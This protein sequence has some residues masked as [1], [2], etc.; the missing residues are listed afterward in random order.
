MP[1]TEYF[2]A[3]NLLIWGAKSVGVCEAGEIFRKKLTKPHF[4]MFGPTIP[5]EVQKLIGAGA[6]EVERYRR[7][8]SLKLIENSPNPMPMIGKPSS[9][10]L[11]IDHEQ[12]IFLDYLVEAPNF[13][14][15]HTV[16]HEFMEQFD[17]TSGANKYHLANL[18]TRDSMWS[19]H[20][21]TLVQP[22]KGLD[23]SYVILLDRFSRAKSKTKLDGLII[24]A[25]HENCVIPVTARGQIIPRGA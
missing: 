24:N 6:P 4:R 15:D 12:N 9:M 10:F 19:G 13:H 18:F 16:H 17:L 1:I 3:E 20:A 14:R 11:F 8:L 23:Y 25:L 7:G 2:H 22:Y 21:A 5:A